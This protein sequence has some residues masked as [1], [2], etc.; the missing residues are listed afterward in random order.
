MESGE[1]F[2]SALSPVL[3]YIDDRAEVSMKKKGASRSDR[4][5]NY[6]KNNMNGSTG[7]KSSSI[8]T[9]SGEGGTS[10]GTTAID[11]AGRTEKVQLWKDD[12]DSVYKYYAKKRLF[13]HML[14]N[15][16]NEIDGSRK[17]ERVSDTNGST[18]GNDTAEKRA[19]N[20]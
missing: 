8:G 4:S 15:S 7:G 11:T 20:I 12:S 13:P 14:S 18:N 9:A 1:M 19:R 16:L 17:D 3:R 2:E 10:K 5:E 6:S